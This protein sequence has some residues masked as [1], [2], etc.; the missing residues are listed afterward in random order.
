MSVLQPTYTLHPIHASSADI[1]KSF[2]T[3]KPLSAEQINFLD[4]HE[5]ELSGEVYDPVI[6]Y[7]LDSVKRK[8]LRT[9]FLLPHEIMNYDAIQDLKLRIQ[10]TLRE[11][12]YTHVEVPIT[13]Q[14]LMQF[15]QNAGQELLYWN[16]NQFIT[17][18]HLYPNR[19]PPVVF[20][21]WGNLFCVIRYV[22]LAI[23]K[24]FKP[25]ITLYFEYRN[26]RDLDRCVF[27]YNLQT[28]KTEKLQKQFVINN[29]L[30]NPTPAVALTD[31]YIL[32][33]H[34]Q[35]FSQHG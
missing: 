3:G 13:E 26:D 7:Y 19:I 28:E 5:K 16:G 12:K 27:D 20:L 29:K 30:V 22:V 10:S 25:Q 21:R 1:L 15:R 8:T 6:R 34:H 17:G 18:P 31:Y 35:S 2:A 9:S 11:G 33:H 23:G 14:Q 32:D 4:W 24:Q